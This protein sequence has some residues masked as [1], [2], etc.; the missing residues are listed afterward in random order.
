MAAGVQMAGDATATFDDFARASWPALWRV[1]WALTFDAHEA[2]DLAQEALARTMSRWRRLRRDDQDAYA[3]ARRV[4]VNLRT[5]RWRRGRLERRTMPGQVERPPASAEE[6]VDDRD[7]LTRLL[8]ELGERERRV[9]VLR[10][11]LDLPVETV[12][13]EMSM[14]PGNV[15]VVAM[16]ALD[17]LRLQVRKEGEGHAADRG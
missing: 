16:R 14:S 9:V 12:A 1:A 5:D 15:R 8:G 10:Y 2:E 3:Y 7:E 6:R 11:L 4:L 17:R 13:E